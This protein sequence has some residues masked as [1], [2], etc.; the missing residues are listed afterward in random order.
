MDHSSCY[1]SIQSNKAKS[2]VAPPALLGA[3][4]WLGLALLRMSLG[5]LSIAAGGKALLFLKEGSS[6]WLC[7]TAYYS[8]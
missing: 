7:C 6:P 2:L 1:H 8:A 5:N 3:G 4:V